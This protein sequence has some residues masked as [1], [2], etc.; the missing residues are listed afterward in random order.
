[1]YD[2][3]NGKERRAGGDFGARRRW[4]IVSGTASAPFALLGAFFFRRHTGQ[5]LPDDVLIAVVTLI[6]VMTNHVIVCFWDVHELVNAYVGRRA[7]GKREA[8]D[9][10]TEN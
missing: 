10:E 4:R 8:E 1:M 3:W 2:D 9:V 6:G 5:E 7:R